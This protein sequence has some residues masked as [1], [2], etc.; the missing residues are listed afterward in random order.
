MHARRCEAWRVGRWERRGRRCAEDLF[1]RR[2]CLYVQGGSIF[3]YLLIYMQMYKY[4]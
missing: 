2:R 1:R 4:I 3:M